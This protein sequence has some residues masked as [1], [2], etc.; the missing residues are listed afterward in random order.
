MAAETTWTTSALTTD[1]IPKGKP[2]REIRADSFI[3][4][5]QLER[6]IAPEE[7]GRL[8]F[9]ARM[10]V[11]SAIDSF[12]LIAK[13]A[14]QNRGSYCKSEK[15]TPDWNLD[16]VFSGYMPTAQGA[17]KLIEILY[18]S[19]TNFKAPKEGPTYAHLKSK[20]LELWP[21]VAKL[22]KLDTLS[23]QS[24]MAT[25]A[26][27]FTQANQAAVTEPLEQIAT[28]VITERFD[29]LVAHSDYTHLAR[30]DFGILF[31]HNGQIT[32]I[33][34][35]LD[36]YSRLKDEQQTTAQK[37]L[38]VKRRLGDYKDSERRNLDDPS[39]TQGKRYLVYNWLATEALTRFVHKITWLKF[40]N[41]HV[42]PV[43]AIDLESPPKFPE[44]DCEVALEFIREEG[45]QILS[46]MPKLTSQ[47]K[48]TARLLVESAVAE[49]KRSKL[50]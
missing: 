4:Y 30:P 46:P 29:E 28:R 50:A 41:G 47:E 2:E 33:Q 8:F 49:S 48:D 40:P 13:F 9:D 42:R 43:F 14:F 16:D 17:S 26:D 5:S 10:Q 21:Q 31:R 44:Q 7:V 11:G 18:R 15:E 37:H 24:T 34:V 36:Y 38:L 22:H 45:S 27:M 6:M 12:L 35:Q 25:Q 19:R 39:T 1:L 3:T 32:I 20:L 23:A